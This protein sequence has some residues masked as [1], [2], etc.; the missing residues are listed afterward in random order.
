[1]TFWAIDNGNLV[2]YPSGS[3]VQ[4]QTLIPASEF[5][6]SAARVMAIANQAFQ[7]GL[8]AK[9]AQIQAALQCK[10]DRD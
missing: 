4:A 2:M 3:R 5:P 6:I 8:I 7:A 1:M 9:A 10:P